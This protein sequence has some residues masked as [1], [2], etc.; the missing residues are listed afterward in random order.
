MA[1]CHRSMR[2]YIVLSCAAL[3]AT[4]HSLPTLRSTAFCPQASGL[5]ASRFQV[6]AK[7][8]LLAA[9]RSAARACAAAVSVPEPEPV[10]LAARLR[11][12]LPPTDELKKIVPLAMMFFCILFNYTILRD[13]KDVLVVTAPGSSAE[14][15]PF[16]KTWVNLPGAIAFTVLYSSMANRLGR[17][18]PS[19]LTAHC[20]PLAARRSPLTAR[21]FSS[22]FTLTLHPQPSPS[23]FTLTLHYQ[24]SPSRFT[25]THHPSPSP[26]PLPPSPFTLP[27]SPFTLTL[28]PHRSRQSCPSP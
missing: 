22:P 6:A 21:R 4:L 17:Q 24:P 1:M 20:S 12:K 14:A 28:H 23:T 16:L 26:F 8:A 27:P 7:P 19:P 9:R 11:A 18:V 10:G 2:V 25:L 3:G 5:A 15:I 13:T